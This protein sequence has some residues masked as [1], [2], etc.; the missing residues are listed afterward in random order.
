MN[1]NTSPS[2]DE[3]LDQFDEPVD[4]VIEAVP[5]GTL[6]SMKVAFV[7][8]GM[9]IFSSC[10]GKSIMTAESASAY[11]PP[12]RSM[13]DRVLQL[14][15]GFLCAIRPSKIDPSARDSFGTA[16]PDA[17]VGL[18][19]H[20]VAFPNR[21]INPQHVH[22]HL[23][24]SGGRPF[25]PNSS[26]F[27]AR[28]FLEESLTSG[29][30]VIQPAYHNRSRINGSVE[31]GG[32][33]DVDNCAGRV[34]EEKIF[35]T[36]LSNVVD[37]PLADSIAQ[38]LITIVSYLK[39]SGFEFPV[40]FTTDSSVDWTKLNI[41]GHSQGS[42]HALYI[43]KT[44]GAH[45]VCIIGGIH[46]VPDNIPPVPVRNLADW[47]IDPSFSMSKTQIKGFLTQEDE[48]YAKFSR[49]LNFLGIGFSDV[50]SPPYV[51]WDNS[52]VNGHG[53]SIKDPRFS[54]QRAEACFH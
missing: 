4:R 15:R 35:G 54:A 45:H 18:G 30:I 25:N 8:L 19:Y 31:C 16:G 14:R 5:G 44:F 48:N 41:G 24:G 50:S 49:T 22:V 52:P 40:E 28:T 6:R 47:L 43:G 7:I 20:V 42:G 51:D 12:N 39:N 21:A 27:G 32:N 46:D 53:G 1:P 29:F 26:E 33:P 2:I 10:S 36:D 23:G 11:S 38:R 9:M 13:C 37:V 34:R 3:A 17:N